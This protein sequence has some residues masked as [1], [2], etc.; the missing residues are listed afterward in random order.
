[1]ALHHNIPQGHL[2]V[3]AKGSSHRKKF[4]SRPGLG[5]NGHVKKIVK[6]QPVLEEKEAC[7]LKRNR[8]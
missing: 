3:H 2:T 8:S 7:F 6:E 4:S 1:M 5:F